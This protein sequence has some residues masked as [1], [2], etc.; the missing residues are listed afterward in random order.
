MKNEIIR[1]LMCDDS[2]SSGVRLASRLRELGIFAYTRRN[3]GEV[4]LSSVLSDNPDVVVADLSLRDTDSVAIMQKAKSILAQSPAFVIL[5]EIDNSFI[6]RQV[7]DS[8]AAYFLPKPFEAERL[9][10][11]IKSVTVKKTDG[12]CFDA[13]ILVTEMIQNLGIPAHIKGYRYIR[14]AILE[15]LANR[16]CLDSITKHLYPRVASKHETT[17][18]RV[19]RAIRHAIETAWERGSRENI[20]AFFGYSADSYNR[21]TN[22]EFI[23]LAADKICLCMKAKI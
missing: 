23:A 16:S 14:T 13:E 1:A 8:G 12:S 15:C 19:E 5:S 9:Y 22:S 3:E 11:V 2:A 4:I 21:P 17:P 10:D 20:N 18:S 6:E 7:I